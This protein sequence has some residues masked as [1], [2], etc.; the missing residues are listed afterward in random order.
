MKD[1][2][3]CAQTVSSMTS[4]L[5]R[6]GRHQLGPLQGVVPLG[7]Q[8]PLLR[9]FGDRFNPYIPANDDTRSIFIHVPKCAGTSVARSIYGSSDSHLPISRYAAFDPKRFEHYFK[10]TFVRNPWD[11]LLS[12]YTYLAP[13][14]KGETPWSHQNLREFR[15]FEAFVLALRDPATRKRV[16]R[17]LHFRPQISWLTLPGG[18]IPP[19]DFT[20]RFERLAEDFDAIVTRLGVDAELPRLNASNAGPYREAYSTQMRNVVAEV[21]ERDIRAFGYSF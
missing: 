8:A 16:L 15:D 4:E 7:I 6:F 13:G 12:A 9:L 14:A 17:F 1:S 19:L 2:F 21:Y 5:V 10:F 20:G 11:R 18:A 3:E